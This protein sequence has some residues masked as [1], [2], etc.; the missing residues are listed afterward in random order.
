[1]K[2]GGGANNCL[3]DGVGWVEYSVGTVGGRQPL[4][5]GGVPVGVGRGPSVV[6]D[7]VVT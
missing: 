6:T 3:N 5:V 2:R 4:Q 7:G 1:M